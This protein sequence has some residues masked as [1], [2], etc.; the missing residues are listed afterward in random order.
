MSQKNSGPKKGLYHSELVKMGPVMV[1]VKQGRTPSKYQ[2]QPD[3]CVLVIDDNERFY[4]IENDDCGDFLDAYEGQDIEIEAQGSREQATIDIA[5]DVPNDQPSP[6]RNPV[7]NRP[8]PA[9]ER[10][11]PKTAPARSGP[12]PATK[13]RPTGENRVAT[14]PRRE[15]EARK[16]ELT[17]RE[18]LVK[19]RKLAGQLSNA[20]YLAVAAAVKAAEGLAEHK[21][22]T[23]TDDLL[24]SLAI[25][26][27]IRFLDSG[28]HLL[29]P[30]GS[31][32]ATLHPAEEVPAQEEG[33]PNE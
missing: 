19:A 17:P 23:V 27:L 10:Q 28:T 12:Q 11:A 3:Y 8:S 31:M 33:E 6:A 5:D 15:T 14:P 2:N 1:T 25:S 18:K 21:I 32:E 26:N 9:Q 20:N 24:K 29:L 30:S 7:Q 16:E 22:V 13:T 4:S